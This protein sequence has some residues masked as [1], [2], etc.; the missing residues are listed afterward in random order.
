MEGFEQTKDQ[1]REEV[2]KRLE[3]YS[4]DDLRTMGMVV[5]WLNNKVASAGF[6]SSTM[7]GRIY[8]DLKKAELFYD[9]GLIDGSVDML[10]DIK[11]AIADDPQLNSFLSQ[12]AM[13]FQEKVK[14][15]LNKPK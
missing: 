7:E 9:A 13:D 10:R 2:I 3:D 6:D 12:N 1:K 5:E 4:I 14:D 15:L 11:L 8:F